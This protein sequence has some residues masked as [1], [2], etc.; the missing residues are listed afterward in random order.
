LLPPWSLFCLPFT[1]TGYRCRMDPRGGCGPAPVWS[2]DALKDLVVKEDADEGSSLAWFSPHDLGRDDE[3][4]DLWLLIRQEQLARNTRGP[5]LEVSDSEL[6]E[7]LGISKR[8]ACDYREK[9]A[10]LRLVA[11]KP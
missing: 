1:K 6:A 5:G 8:T 9:L 7:G 3:T 2:E 10:K 4:P 11:A